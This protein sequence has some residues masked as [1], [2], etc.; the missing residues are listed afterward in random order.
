ML[1]DI[2]LRLRV[3]LVQVALEV[4][5]AH[6]VTVFEFT[7]VVAL[8]LNGVVGQVDESVAQVAQ[9]ELLRGSPDVPVLIEVALQRFVD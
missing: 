5:V 7:E 6:F 3:V 2:D 9:V 8:L 4:A 1:D